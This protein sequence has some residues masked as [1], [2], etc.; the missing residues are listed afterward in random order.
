M[1]FFNNNKLLTK[2]IRVGQCG[3]AL[4]ESVIIF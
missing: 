3:Y 1:Y 2:Y 4:V